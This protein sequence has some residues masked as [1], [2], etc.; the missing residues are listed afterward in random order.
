MPTPTGIAAPD[1]ARVAA[2]VAAARRA[3]A[4]VEPDA[5]ALVEAVLTLDEAEWPEEGAAVLEAALRFQQLSGPAMAKGLEDTA[6]Y[7]Y[8]RLIALNEVGSEPGRFGTP[9]AAF[10]AANAERLAKGAL[11]LLGTST[12]DTKR[13]EDAR[14]RIAALPHH[15]AA[16]EAAVAEWHALLADEGAPID[17]NDEYFFYQLLVGAWP[18]EWREEPGAAA[19][20]ALAERVQAAMLKSVREAGENTRWV[21]GDAGYEARLAG[22]VGRALAPG[23]AYLRSFRAF[24]ARLAPDGAANALIQAALKLTLPGV[25]DVYRGAEAW[26]QSLVD[27][28]NRR[29]VDFGDL[30]RRLADLPPGAAAFADWT[31]PTAKLALT[32]R[33]LAA[34]R[35]RPGLFAV[36]SYEPVEA[37]ARVCGFRR[38]HEAAEMLVLAALRH[39]GAATRLD[40]D[41]T[42]TDM[43]TGATPKGGAEALRGAAGRR[44]APRLRRW[45]RGT[46]RRRATFQ[47]RRRRRRR[48]A[49]C[50]STREPGCWWPTASDTCSCATTAPARGSTCG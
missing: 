30:A 33:L 22:F 29:P 46:D 19:L 42:W 43:L 11:G 8:N 37:G 7:R 2:A 44:P 47:T 26:E 32:A 16:W 27:P 9:L 28:D 20:A 34:R 39:A 18:M 25:P 50:G 41:G 38:R 10:H 5:F 24:E 4:W 14:A 1:R 31:S 49:S 48:S 23:G 12:H 15:A 45:F 6:L 3:A 36:G 21:F 35:E 40:L 17:R 13:G